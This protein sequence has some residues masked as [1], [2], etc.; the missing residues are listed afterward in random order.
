MGTMR[1]TLYKLCVPIVVLVVPV[2][3]GLIALSI[4]RWTQS[5]LALWVGTYFG[6]VLPQIYLWPYYS[7]FD[8][9]GN[10]PFDRAMLVSL[11]PWAVV[12]L[13]SFLLSRKKSV[14]TM[15]LV[16]LVIGTRYVLA[17]HILLLLL[18]Y[19]FHL[20]SF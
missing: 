20:D 16:F 2:L 11:V 1:S 6:G 5:S 4:Y 12:V 19:E 10:R 14:K 13:L 9:T 3:L 17:L 18:G 7:Y 15:L 8:Q